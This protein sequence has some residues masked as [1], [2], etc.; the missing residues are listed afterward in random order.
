MAVDKWNASYYTD[1]DSSK[2]VF[3]ENRSELVQRQHM[4]EQ[5]GGSKLLL[6]IFKENLF[7][8]TELLNEALQLGIIYLYN[9]N[10]HCQNSLLNELIS[11][12]DNLAFVSLRNLIKNIGDFLI[13]VRK[14]K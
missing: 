1:G 3:D 5:C 13:E 10:T 14:F 11:D 7:Q 12:P 8:K 9:G 6:S 4:I 2:D